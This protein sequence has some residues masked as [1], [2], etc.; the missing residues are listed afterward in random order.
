MVRDKWSSNIGFILASIGSAVGI[1][2]IWRFP[3]IVGDNGGGA[4]LIAYIIAVFLFGLPLMILE[5]SLG[6]HFKTSVVPA[7][8]TLGKKFETAGLFLV[9][10]MVM[11]LGYY[12]VVTSW[13]LAYSLFFLYGASVPFSQFTDSYYP[14]IFFLTS[15]GIVFLVVR[16]GISRG[17]EKLARI[18]IPVLT[19]MLLF[20]LVT[21]LS[22][23]GAMQGVAFYLTPDFSKLSNPSVWTAAFGQAFFSLSVGTGTM[24]TYASYI[25]NGNI[26]KNSAVIAF[27]DLV[28]AILAGFVIFPLVFSFGLDPSSGVQLTF[29]TLPLIFHEMKFGLILGAMFFTLLFFAAI[30]SAVSFLEVPVATLIDHYNIERKK[31]TAIISTSIVIVGIPPALSY[32]ALKLGLL[33][34]PL[35]DHYDLVFGTLGI[36]TAGLVLTIIGGWFVK[37]EYILGQIAGGERIKMVFMVIVKYFIPLLLII[38]LASVITGMSAG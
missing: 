1:G 27:S 36:I 11:I 10:I 32:T 35:L 8:S 38:N 15:A 24:L 20:L 17:I 2:N 18:L 23:P 31:A 22:R 14:L 30:T 13:V 19:L 9:F 5:F 6:R 25:R 37:Q 12:L 16:A 26:V 3:Y 28:I 4:F 29:V 21:S 33:G 34:K 7:F